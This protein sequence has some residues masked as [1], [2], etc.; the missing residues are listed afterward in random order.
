MLTA[1]LV[2]CVPGIPRLQWS[3]GVVSHQRDFVQVTPAACRILLLRRPMCPASLFAFDC[4]ILGAAEFHRWTVVQHPEP[5]G[6]GLKI[7]RPESRLRTAAAKSVMPVD[8][9]EWTAF[10]FFS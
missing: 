2:V 7:I 8:I 3:G 5:P 6:R 9:V 4:G 1:L 10:Q